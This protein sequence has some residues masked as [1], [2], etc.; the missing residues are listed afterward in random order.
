MS[1]GRLF[2]CEQDRLLL[3]GLLLENVGLD[4]AVNAVRLARF[5]GTGELF[6]LN[7]QTAYELDVER[8]RLGS[9]LEKAVTVLSRAS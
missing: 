9:R 6:W 2:W 5:F 7:L 3:L 4:R 8:D 1:N